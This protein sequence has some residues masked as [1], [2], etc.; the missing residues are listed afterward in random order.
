MIDIAV[1]RDI[2]PQVN[3]IENIY[4]YNI[5]NL[6]AIVQNNQQEREKEAQKAEEIIEREAWYFLGW[7]EAQNAV[8]TIKS[9]REKAERIRQQEMEKTL[10]RVSVS[11]KEREAVNAMTAAIVNQ[12]L[13]GP[14]SYIKQQAH[15]R[16]GFNMEAVR[17]L[18]DLDGS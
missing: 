6:H 1:P 5:D 14:I 18:F 16:N 3:E 9:L 12:L 4:L 11:E 10:S 7:L 15:A 13:H 17:Q 8:P 2:N